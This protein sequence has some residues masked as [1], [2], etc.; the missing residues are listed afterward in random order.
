MRRVAGISLCAAVWATSLPA[1]TPL[2]AAAANVQ[3]ALDICIRNYN[4]PDQLHGM[5]VQA[6]FTHNP[7]DF[8]GE[9]ANWYETPGNT[10]LVTFYRNQR[11]GSTECQISTDQMDVTQMLPFTKAVMAQNFPAIAVLDGTP[12]G[13]NVLP[14]T[15]AANN[16]PCSGFHFLVPRMMIWV[17]LTRAGND[18]TCISDGSSN[19][20][21]VM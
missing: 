9:I 6:G 2:E 1:V 5:L 18:G 16:G 7:E 4:T 12:E 19:L 3:L 8:G 13:Q 20:R 17:Q 11:T 15:P 21:V 14:G 10:A